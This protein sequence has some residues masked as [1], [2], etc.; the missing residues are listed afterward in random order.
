MHSMA[1]PWERGFNDSLQDNLCPF[2]GDI[3]G[4]SLQASGVLQCNPA[5]GTQLAETSSEAGAKAAGCS[6]LRGKAPNE[7]ADS[8]VGP[9]QTAQSPRL[10]A[11]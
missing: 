11:R 7:N 4:Q 10:A 2:R 3:R 1:L 9:V 8:A 6:G 5:I